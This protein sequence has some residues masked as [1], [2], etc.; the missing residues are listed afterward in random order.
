MLFDLPR[1]ADMHSQTTRVVAR[2][3]ACIALLNGMLWAESPRLCSVRGR[4]VNAV[5]EQPSLPRQELE[6]ISAATAPAAVALKG[7]SS[8]VQ[9]EAQR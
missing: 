6:V 4:V 2:L 9:N 1:E 5:G 7:T 8:K 3:L